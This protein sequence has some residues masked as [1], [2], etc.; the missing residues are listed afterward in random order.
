[1]SR[2]QEKYENELMG[3]IQQKLGLKN[4]MEVPRIS[5]ITLNMG[6]GGAIADKKVLERTQNLGNSLALLFF[7]PGGVR[8]EYG[9]LV[10]SQL[11]RNL[12]SRQGKATHPLFD[13]T[14]LGA[15]RPQE[16]TPRWRVVEKIVDL[17]RR[18]LRVRSRFR[19]AD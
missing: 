15:L 16:T 14:E 2:L 7:R 18:A 19:F 8:L 12:R 13:M 17:N 11:K 9:A 10:V 4:P 6:V 5:K 3:E 1:M